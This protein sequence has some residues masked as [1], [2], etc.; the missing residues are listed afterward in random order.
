MSYTDPDRDGRIAELR[1]QLEESRTA[2]A[3]LHKLWRAGLRE[4]EAEEAWGIVNA[5]NW[6]NPD[7]SAGT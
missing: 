6:G 1:T 4:A 5:L 3:E 2:H 7:G